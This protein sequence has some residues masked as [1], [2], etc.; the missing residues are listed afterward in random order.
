MANGADPDTAAC[1]IA[2]Q[3]THSGVC[4]NTPAPDPYTL[5]NQAPKPNPTVT[6]CTNPSKPTCMHPAPEPSQ[7]L[8]AA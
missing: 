4:P 2:A 1:L 3:E 8:Q 6:V 5:Q 7:Q